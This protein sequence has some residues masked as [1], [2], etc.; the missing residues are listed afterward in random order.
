VNELLPANQ[1]LLAGARI[2]TEWL[3]KHFRANPLPGDGNRTYWFAMAQ[4]RH[5]PI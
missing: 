2:G 1:P 5:T 3:T 4:E